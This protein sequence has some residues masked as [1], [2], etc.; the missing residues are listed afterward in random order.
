[1]SQQ[2]ERRW[3]PAA[4]KLLRDWE[5]QATERCKGHDTVGQ[6]LERKHYFYGSIATVIMAF[7]TSSGFATF[8]NCDPSESWC[9]AMQWIRL[10]ASIFSAISV[11][12]VAY[13]TFNNFQNKAEDHKKSAKAYECLQRDIL[14]L[15]STPISLRGDPVETL[16]NFRE[17]MN[18]IARE[19]P[20]L[21][22][23]Y[24]KDIE[25]PK[26]KSSKPKP[27]PPPPVCDR[28][29]QEDDILLEKL[30]QTTS[31]DDYSLK[32]V[33]HSPKIFNNHSSKDSE[34]L[35][36]S[37]DF[38]L[39]TL[40]FESTGGVR[41]EELRSISE[42]LRL[43]I[44]KLETSP[45][46]TYNKLKTTKKKRNS[47][48]NGTFSSDAP[49]RKETSSNSENEIKDTEQISSS[50]PGNSPTSTEISDVSNS[51]GKGI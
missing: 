17:K 35:D 8:Q 11:A 23:K 36:N 26:T 34:I 38:D 48:K 19:A 1:M 20:S 16:I 44:N 50:S 25:P 30:L 40:Q 39:D 28:D 24:N 49:S 6:Q 7:I 4:N 9:E 21:P 22:K 10:T 41:D 2:P 15:L 13:Q 18:T 27:P 37:D 29:K 32:S 51:E 3:T 43:E 46:N 33:S 31:N 45:K 42:A 5:V 12:I 14:S 47:N